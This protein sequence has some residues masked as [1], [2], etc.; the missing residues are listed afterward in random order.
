MVQKTAVK[1]A[2]KKATKTRVEADVVTITAEQFTSGVAAVKKAFDT[3]ARI[4]QNTS[5]T[6]LEE[7]A[8]PHVMQGSWNSSG[9]S[10]TNESLH[11]RLNY[12]NDLATATRASAAGLHDRILFAGN[13]AGQGIT[14]ADSSTPSEGAMK[15]RVSGTAQ[16]LH[17][18]VA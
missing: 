9:P 18:V 11:V 2:A 6:H 13:T 8:E 5:P 10:P 1:E 7:P 15:D 14:G 4:E 3:L 12:L 17:Y 16:A